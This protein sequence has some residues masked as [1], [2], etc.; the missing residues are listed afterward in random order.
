MAQPPQRGPANNHGPKQQRPLLDLRVFVELGRH[1]QEYVRLVQNIDV[2]IRAD[3]RERLRDLDRTFVPELR[4]ASSRLRDLEAA[5]HAYSWSVDRLVTHTLSTPEFRQRLKDE[6]HGMQR[7]KNG[8]AHEAPSLLLE[9]ERVLGNSITDAGLKLERFSESRDLAEDQLQR[10]AGLYGALKRDLRE[11]VVRLKDT[12]SLA[13]TTSLAVVV[14]GG[15]VVAI[16]AFAC[17][18]SA[19]ITIPAAVVAAISKVFAVGGATVSLAKT[20]AAV[21]TLATAL[22]SGPFWKGWYGKRCLKKLHQAALEEVE[23]IETQTEELQDQTALLG[24]VVHETRLRLDECQREFEQFKVSVDNGYDVEGYVLPALESLWRS[25]E[26]Y[27]TSM[28]PLR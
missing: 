22:I 12:E 27:Q 5:A 11:L 17:V 8:Q 20:V 19:P 18:G 28:H 25:A 16:A 15:G 9:Y 21:G 7:G 14:V 13:F 23:R 24:E 1:L 6:I 10:L 4:Q 3:I 26:E 2:E